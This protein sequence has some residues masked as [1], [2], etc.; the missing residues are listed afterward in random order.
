[1][2]SNTIRLPTLRARVPRP[3]L[4]AVE[5]AAVA[6]GTTVSAAARELLA[7]ALAQRGLWPPA[8]EVPRGDL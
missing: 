1:M 8:V 6:S 4:A 3:M 5:R 2:S 7:L